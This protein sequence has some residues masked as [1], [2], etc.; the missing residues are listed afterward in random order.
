MHSNRK[1][2]TKWQQAGH[3]AHKLMLMGE[4]PLIDQMFLLL[5]EKYAHTM[6]IYQ[7]YR[8]FT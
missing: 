3:G 4:E 5:N 8:S 6:Q 1:V 7:Q 2:L